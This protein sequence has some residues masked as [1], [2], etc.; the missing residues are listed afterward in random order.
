MTPTPYE[1][2]L[3]ARDRMVVR[4][5]GTL[6]H[7]TALSLE[8]ALT[9]QTAGLT[10]Q[11]CV[12]FDLTAFEECVLSARSVLVRLQKLISSRV[13]RTAFVADRPKARGLALWVMHL[14]DDSNAKAV[15][16][17]AMAEAWFAQSTGRVEDAQARMTAT[18]KSVQIARSRS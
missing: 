12:L 2:S 3:A 8:R 11:A 18:L 16:N 10:G 6:E 5:R 1:I 9:E 13:R 4:V 7:D 17:M 15:P 14:A